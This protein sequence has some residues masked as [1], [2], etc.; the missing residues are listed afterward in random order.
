MKV[1]FKERFVEVRISLVAA[2]ERMQDWY[3]LA[4]YPNEFEANE[5]AR[6]VLLNGKAKRAKVV[7]EQVL[8]AAA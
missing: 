8:V 4:R 3:L 2:G 6:L 7:I 1:Q 5:A